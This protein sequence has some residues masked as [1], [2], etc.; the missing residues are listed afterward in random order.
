MN[1]SSSLLRIKLASFSF[2]SQVKDSVVGA[3]KSVAQDAK[4][5]SVAA[6]QVLKDDFQAV[7]EAVAEASDKIG[8]K[9]RGSG[10]EQFKQAEEAA[11]QADRKFVMDGNT[12]NPFNKAAKMAQEAKESVKASVSSAAKRAKESLSEPAE[13]MTQ[14]AGNVVGK[15]KIISRPSQILNLSFFL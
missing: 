4:R 5:A 12:E 2:S 13:S 1:F 7:A 6:S 14:K 11:K 3:G 10:E 8:G 15:G 9:V